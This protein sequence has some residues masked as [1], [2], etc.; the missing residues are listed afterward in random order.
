MMAAGAT[1]ETS[2]ARLYDFS[3]IPLCFERRTPLTGGVFELL[4]KRVSPRNR[5]AIARE[6]RN[7]AGKRTK[8]G[9]T[10]NL[11]RVVNT[12]SFLTCATGRDNFIMRKET[13]REI[14]GCRQ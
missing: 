10:S 6:T 14:G 8:G 7:Q 9:R 3:G 4:W 12:Q 2:V 13:Q 5:L 1:R 11:E